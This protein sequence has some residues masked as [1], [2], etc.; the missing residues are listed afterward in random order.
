MV[1]EATDKYSQGMVDTDKL[2]FVK[3]DRIDTI[4]GMVDT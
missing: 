1:V 2:G 3:R 4:P